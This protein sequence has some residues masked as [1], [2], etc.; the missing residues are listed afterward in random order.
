M[1]ITESTYSAVD[2]EI[3][4]C[5]LRWNRLLLTAPIFNAVRY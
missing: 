1:Q 5:R 4:V 2:L 3:M